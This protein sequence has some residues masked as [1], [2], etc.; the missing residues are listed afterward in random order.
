MCTNWCLTRF[1]SAI[2]ASDVISIPVS[3]NF[4]L[5]KKKKKK[6]HPVFSFTIFRADIVVVGGSALFPGFADRL[7]KEITALAPSTCKVK[8]VLPPE[9]KYSVWVRKKK[10]KKKPEILK[11]FNADWWI[12][13]FVH[14]AP[15]SLGPQR[16][17]RRTRPA[18]H[19]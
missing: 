2:S 5:Q 13:Y 4:P 15:V 6:K 8:V 12:N 18:N 16:R 10:K 3:K 19:Q 7:M 1:A 11:F 9:A 14:L 17:V